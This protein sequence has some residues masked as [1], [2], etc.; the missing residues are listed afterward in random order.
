MN[1][2]QQMQAQ[3]CVQMA[4]RDLAK[5]LFR[6]S[7]GD[8]QFGFLAKLLDVECVRLDIASKCG[9]EVA[10][11]FRAQ[12]IDHGYDFDDEK[13]LR[14]VSDKVIEK[15]QRPKS[16]KM[17]KSKKSYP[18]Q[19][20]YGGYGNNR[21]YSYNR[22]GD[23]NGGNRYGNGNGNGNGSNGNGGQGQKQKLCW[24]CLSPNHYKGHVSCK[25]RAEPSNQQ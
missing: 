2:S 15:H 16:E 6:R 8:L 1:D 10:N 18:Y 23:F 12:I 7:G 24:D 4:I 25:G 11:E 9:A 5:E 14:K 20:P 13:E 3:K 21:G 19:R 22:G 17:G